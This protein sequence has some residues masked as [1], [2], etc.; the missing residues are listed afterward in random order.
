MSF[1]T[2][3]AIVSTKL[4]GFNCCYITQIIPFDINRLFVHS[5]VVTS[6]ANTNHSMKYKSFVCTQRSCY[7]Y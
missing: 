2:S 6:I 1:H 5:E 7:K 3:I 4:N